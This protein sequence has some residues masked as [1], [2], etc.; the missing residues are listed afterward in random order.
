MVNKKVTKVYVVFYL[1]LKIAIKTGV[2]VQ[3]KK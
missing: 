1:P 2:L 3:N